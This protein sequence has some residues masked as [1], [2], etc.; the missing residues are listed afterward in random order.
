M[1]TYSPIHHMPLTEEE[2][3]RRKA[4]DSAVLSRYVDYLKEG[5]VMQELDSV[6]FT[7]VTL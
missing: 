3:T 7:S 1:P 5:S 2:C 6:R 4:H